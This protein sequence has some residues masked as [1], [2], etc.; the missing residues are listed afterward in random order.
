MRA[1]PFARYCVCHLRRQ[2]R[3]GRRLACL[4]KCLSQG[5]RHQLAT[6]T[7]QVGRRALRQRLGIGRAGGIAALGALRAGQQRQQRL[8]TG[9]GVC[10]LNH[11]TW[12]TP[13]WGWGEEFELRDLSEAGGA[14]RT[15]LH[16]PGDKLVQVILGAKHMAGTTDREA[17][18]VAG[19]NAR[20][21]GDDLGQCLSP[22]RAMRGCAQ[23]VQNDHKIALTQP[24]GNVGGANDIPL[25][26]RQ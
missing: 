22:L 20:R 19:Q 4:L 12:H 3:L 9:R 17:E 11:G 5:L 16:G 23:F 26:L 2:R 6:R 13:D 14:G 24:A 15:R 7:A 8:R 10:L 25:R 21:V 1:F 18:R